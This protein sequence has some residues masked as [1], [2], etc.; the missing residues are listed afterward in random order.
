MNNIQDIQHLPMDIIISTET[1]DTIINEIDMTEAIILDQENGIDKAITRDIKEIKHYETRNRPAQALNPFFVSHK[2]NFKAGALI[3]NTPGNNKEEHKSYLANMLR[4]PKTQKSLIK[5]DFFNGNGWYTIHFNYK[6]DMIEC[7]QKTNN[8]KNEDFKLL[9]L[10]GEPVEQKVLQTIENSKSEKVNKIQDHLS[11]IQNPSITKENHNPFDLSDKRTDWGLGMLIGAFPGN[12]RRE[13]LSILANSL[14]IPEYNDLINLEHI[15]GNSWFT[16]YFQKEQ[17]RSNYLDLLNKSINKSITPTFNTINL[18]SLKLNT[19]KN[20]DKGKNKI[21]ESKTK[22]QILDISE[23]FTINRIKGAIKQYGNIQSFQVNKETNSN[24]KSVTVIFDPINI[25]L[26]E[27]WAIPMGRIMARIAPYDEHISKLNERNEITTRLYGINKDTSAT[28]IM[29]SIK[30]TGAKTVFI[31]KNSKTGKRRTFAIIGFKN[32]EDLI[33]ALSMQISL[34]GCKTWWSTK[35][36]AKIT[37]SSNRRTHKEEN[38]NEESSN[39]MLFEYTCS[40]KE[41]IIDSQTS[42]NKQEKRRKKFEKNNKENTSTN[43]TIVE[44]T[45]EQISNT[46]LQINKR[47]QKLESQHHKTDTRKR[48]NCS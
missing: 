16:C 15:N 39:N 46:L 35:D 23:E 3:A 41:K 22:V 45:W 31:P 32:E 20:K 21:Q 25:N 4:I 11:T 33:K 30:H 36:T 1:G 27:T 48:P 43:T 47:L 42:T 9:Y 29:S 8:K 38:N 2:G 37:R 28:R 18:E 5:D 14:Q 7:V 12:N 24:L 13:Q 10:I 34:F 40:K 26:E 17:Q 44:S 19:P 6:H